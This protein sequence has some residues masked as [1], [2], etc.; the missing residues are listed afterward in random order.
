MRPLL[1]RAS[2]FAVLLLL[3]FPVKGGA[4]QGNVGFVQLTLNRNFTIP[5]FQ[6]Y[7]TEGEQPYLHFNALMRALELPIDFEISLGS[8]SGF[9]AD[10]TTR[11][12]L[13]L[14]RRTLEIGKVSHVLAE[15]AV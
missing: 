13:S 2:L 1:C 5:F 9:L 15:N 6:T 14:E 12:V 11:F 3:L 4:Q 7:F 8:A 10:G